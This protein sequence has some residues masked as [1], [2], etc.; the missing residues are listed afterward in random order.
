MH[1]T[2]AI[3]GWILT[4]L[5]SLN[6][7]STHQA[8]QSVCKTYDL[9]EPLRFCGGLKR[10]STNEVKLKPTLQCNINKKFNYYNNLNKKTPVSA[11]AMSAP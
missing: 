6:F 7:V 8:N 10:S 1:N 4:S 3:V 5:R 9:L 2:K 11:K